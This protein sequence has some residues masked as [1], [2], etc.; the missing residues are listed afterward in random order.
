M[1]TNIMAIE[2]GLTRHYLTD[3][4][5]QR[6]V[7]TLELLPSAKVPSGVATPQSSD[8]FEQY[9]SMHTAFHSI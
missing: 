5:K 1:D 8:L 9:A 7:A 4:A 2:Y 3:G 6:G